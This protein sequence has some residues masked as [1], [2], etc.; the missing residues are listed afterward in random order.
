[1]SGNDVQAA[2]TAP[3][4]GLGRVLTV[5]RIL[6]SVLVLAVPVS[7][8]FVHELWIKV[9][10]LAVFGASVVFWRSVQFVAHRRRLGS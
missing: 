10:L 4:R 2:S 5:A 9:V 6:C 8:L 7:M 3:A 1:M